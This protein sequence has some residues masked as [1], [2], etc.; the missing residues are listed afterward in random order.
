[1]AEH[2]APIPGDGVELVTETEG[3]LSTKPADPISKPEWSVE[4]GEPQQ[5]PPRGPCVTS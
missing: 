5:N 2:A 3:V 1:M 4:S